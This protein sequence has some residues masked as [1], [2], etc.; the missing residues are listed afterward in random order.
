MWWPD[1]AV[2]RGA[3]LSGSDRDRH[4]VG[5]RRRRG[6][7]G[8]PPRDI[9]P[10]RQHVGDARVPDGGTVL[11]GWLERIQVL[12]CRSRPEPIQRAN[13]GGVPGG[14]GQAVRG[15]RAEPG[16]VGATAR[17]DRRRA[18]NVLGCQRA[19]V[20][21]GDQR[22]RDEAA[23]S[24]C[25]RSTAIARR[26]GRGPRRAFD[27]CSGNGPVVIG[28]LRMRCQAGSF[29]GELLDAG[30]VDTSESSGAAS[31]TVSLGSGAY[32]QAAGIRRAPD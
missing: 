13:Q 17:P 18:G 32:R 31:A 4:A 23:V 12:R 25:W 7:C 2:V 8:T 3:Q 24:P 9:R 29:G 16:S 30:G 14:S 15:V 26:L 22:A 21:R 1:G 6:R 5:A 10:D 20:G 11:R 19:G 28:T 27:V